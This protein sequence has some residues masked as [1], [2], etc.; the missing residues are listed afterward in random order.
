MSKFIENIINNVNNFNGVS[1]KK[2]GIL[3]KTITVIIEAGDLLL[4]VLELMFF[5]EMIFMVQPKMLD[6]HLE[7]Q[8]RL[9]KVHMRK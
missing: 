9:P 2:I 6:L 3:N 7:L 4:Q 5:L 8:L 1:A